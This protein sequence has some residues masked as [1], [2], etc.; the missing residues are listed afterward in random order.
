MAVGGRCNLARLGVA[1]LMHDGVAD[2]LSDV[3][4]ASVQPIFFRQVN[5]GVIVGGIVLSHSGGHAVVEDNG[6]LT[7]IVQNLRLHIL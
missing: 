7:G 2:S 4:F 5:A 1:L 6:Y 3:D